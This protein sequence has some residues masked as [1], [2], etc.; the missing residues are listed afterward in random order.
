VERKEINMR[1]SIVIGSIAWLI[2][3]LFAHAAETIKVEN[4][5]ISLDEELMVPAQEAG[6]LRQ[7]PVHDGQHVKVGE[8]LAQIDDLIPQRQKDVAENKLKA[9]NEEANSTVGID[10]ATSAYKVAKVD[11]DQDL[12]A[13]KQM[14]GSVT[15][16][17]ERQDYLKMEE[18]RLSIRKAE[19]DHNVALAQSGVAEAELKAADAN[20]EHRRITSVLDAEVMECK[21][22]VG[23]WVAAGDPLMR[24]VR[25][26]RLRVQGDVLARDFRPSEIANRPV[27]V[28]VELARGEK[29]TLPGKVVWVSP[30]VE[31]GGTFSVR[32]IVENRQENGF[33]VV[34]PGLD[35]SMNIQLK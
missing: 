9:A 15:Q 27:T 8:L 24:L 18:M 12:A 14:L 29:I 16:F 3:P 34:C 6:V 32:A 28:T 11:Y 10:Y 30:I 25:L 5:T 19:K 20:I 4:C 7:L 21:R 1:L 31:Q 13:N 17:K 35:A 22:H 26:N 23:E 33:W 2:A